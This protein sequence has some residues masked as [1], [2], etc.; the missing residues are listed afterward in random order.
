MWRKTHN[1]VISRNDWPG[2]EADIRKWVSWKGHLNS[3]YIYM[4]AQLSKQL[5]EFNQSFIDL[6]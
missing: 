4:K 5:L 6:V 3:L 2:M 1:A